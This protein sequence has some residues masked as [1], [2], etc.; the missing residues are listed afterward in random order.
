VLGKAEYLL[1]QLIYAQSPRCCMCIYHLQ[2]NSHDMIRQASWYL[3]NYK[4]T[5]DRQEEKTKWYRKKPH[6]KNKGEKKTF[7]VMDAMNTETK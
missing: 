5:K 1:V 2:N 7:A 4:N 6:R 3:H